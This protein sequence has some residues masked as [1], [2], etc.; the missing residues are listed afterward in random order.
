[1][2]SCGETRRQINTFCKK[3]GNVCLEKHVDDIEL[4]HWQEPRMNEE[5]AAKHLK[6]KMESLK[7][8]IKLILLSL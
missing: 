2:K 3:R 4:G 7:S 8:Y 5:T 6:I 1:M